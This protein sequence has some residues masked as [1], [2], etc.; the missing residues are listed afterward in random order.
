MR[1]AKISGDRFIA[2]AKKGILGFLF[3]SLPVVLASL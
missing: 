2:S 1:L 3:V